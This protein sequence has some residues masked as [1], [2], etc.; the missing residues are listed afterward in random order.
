M[1]VINSFA[2]FAGATYPVESDVLATAPV[3]GDAQ[4]VLQGAFVPSGATI[5]AVTDVREGVAVGSGG[6]GVLELPAVSQ[7]LLGVGYGANGIEYTGTLTTTDAG[8]E[9]TKDIAFNAGDDY[10]GIYALSWESATFAT[11][12]GVLYFTLVDDRGVEYLQATPTYPD[13][14]TIKLE[15]TRDQTKTIASDVYRYGIRHVS[16]G[17]QVRT[18]VKGFASVALSYANVD[19]A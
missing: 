8:D 4:N 7:V 13:Q 18:L 5:P 15:L 6:V 19:S 10:V 1:A 2:K 3:Y 9:T 12:D 14:Q 16:A 11:M 17:G